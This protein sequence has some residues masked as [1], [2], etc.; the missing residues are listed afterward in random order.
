MSLITGLGSALCKEL[1]AEHSQM[2]MAWVSTRKQLRSGIWFKQRSK[3]AHL[4][5]QELKQ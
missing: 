2:V 5:D 3:Q 1:K 4:L